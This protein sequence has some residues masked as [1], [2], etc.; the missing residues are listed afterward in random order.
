LLIKELKKQAMEVKRVVTRRGY[1][2]QMAVRF[3]DFKPQEDSWY[4]FLLEVESTCGPIVWLK[5]LRHLK[6][7]TTVL[8]GNEAA[9]FWLVV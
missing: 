1:G 8:A 7:S 4:S 3:S 2:S 5:G 6:K 9:T